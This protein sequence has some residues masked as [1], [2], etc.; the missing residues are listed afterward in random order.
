MQVLWPQKHQNKEI[1][2]G[3]YKFRQETPISQDKSLLTCTSEFRLD[4]NIENPCIE[5][6]TA[7]R[8]PATNTPF[9]IIPNK[10]RKR[11]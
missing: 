11:P 7:S 1:L 10:K 6:S 9:E 5:C 3:C 2:G 8:P 4:A